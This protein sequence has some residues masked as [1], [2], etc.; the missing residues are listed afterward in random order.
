MI[1]EITNTAELLLTTLNNFIAAN[2]FQWGIALITLII[3]FFAIKIVRAYVKRFFDNVNLDKT[4]EVFIQK[5]IRVFLWIILVIIVLSNLGFDVTGFIAGLG[6]LGF[7]VGFAT[8][9]VL[10]NLAA[11]MFLLLNRPFKVGDEI[12]AAKIEGKVKAIG[13][14]ACILITEKNE[15]ITIPNSKIWGGPITN[16]SRLKK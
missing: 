5:L 4:L 15:Y 9:D 7:I 11:G 10:S 13:T 14:S 2:L 12:K 8:K 1:E 3:G 6:I 16:L